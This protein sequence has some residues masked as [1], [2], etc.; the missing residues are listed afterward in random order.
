M[1]SSEPLATL[2]Q[3]AA[4]LDGHVRAYAHPGGLVDLTRVA[5]E[6]RSAATTIRALHTE[7]REIERILAGAL[8]Y[9]DGEA[10][11][12]QS[13]EPAIG[14]LT[15]I[16]LATEAAKRLTELQERCGHGC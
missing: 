14:D 13:G 7:R 9:R 1:S 3:L 4:E 2:D 12:P 16:D 5:F 10:G 11:S 15:A 6:I 8:G